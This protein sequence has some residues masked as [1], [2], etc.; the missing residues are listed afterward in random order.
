MVESGAR[1]VAGG[2]ESCW[3]QEVI[4]AD[5]WCVRVTAGG[6]GRKWCQRALGGGLVSRNGVT[7][8]R[9]RRKALLVGGRGVRGK[10]VEERSF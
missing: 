5:T 7:G 9:W 1:V 10:E 6:G 4:L 3:W 2:G 8:S